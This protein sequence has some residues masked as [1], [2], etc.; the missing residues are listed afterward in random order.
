M[1]DLTI[2][3]NGVRLAASVFGSFDL[4]PVLF[5]HGISNSRDTWEEMVAALSGTHQVWT[6]DFR[7]HGHSDRTTAYDILDYLADADAALAAIG[8]RT[9]VVGHSLGACVA[10][11]LAQRPHPLVVGVFLEDPPW[12]LGEPGQ[13]ERSGF[14]KLFPAISSRQSALQAA[15]APLSA[16]LDFLSNAPSPLGGVAKDHLSPRHLL[17]RASALQR[18]DNRCW[19]DKADDLAT[20]RVLSN[21]DT[22]RSFQCPVTVARGDPHLGAALLEGH[23]ARL[24]SANPETRILHYKGCGHL[25]HHTTVFATRFANDITA[26]LAGLTY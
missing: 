18:Q 7:G 6:L 4:P 25:L 12:F 20:G 22:A 19:G 17:S 3:P 8:R 16:Y 24:A 21:I 23:D 1:T 14:F 10:G 9:T 15:N 13:W 26:F 11:V 5:L 2:N